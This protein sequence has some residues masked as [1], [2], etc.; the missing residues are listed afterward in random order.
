MESQ[1]SKSSSSQSLIDM[2]RKIGVGRQ[3]EFAEKLIRTGWKLE[4]P[5]LE[6]TF[7]SIKVRH[8][9]G[10][11][12]TMFV[13]DGIMELDDNKFA[14]NMDQMADMIEAMQFVSQGRKIDEKE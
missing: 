14:M 13:C 3:L 12:T 1:S 5:T 10:S 4:A 9:I 2:P 8:T 7:G 6:K 11:D